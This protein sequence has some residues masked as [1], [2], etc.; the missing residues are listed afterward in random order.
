[1]KR[2]SQEI[3]EIAET[4]RLERYTL[5]DERD[6]LRAQLA[7]AQNELQKTKHD[8]MRLADEVDVLIG[9]KIS[10]VATPPT[11]SS[12]SAIRR[13]LRAPTA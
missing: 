1:M 9:R 12:T 7:E 8:G 10:T 11:R 3:S 6:T 4:H 2:R 5:A 13:V